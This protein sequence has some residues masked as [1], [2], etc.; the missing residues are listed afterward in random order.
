MFAWSFWGVVFFL[1][2]SL[3]GEIFRVLCAVCST[4]KDFPAIWGELGLLFGLFI[5]TPY[6]AG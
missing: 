5:G 4:K 6:P 3:G 1:T 2:Y